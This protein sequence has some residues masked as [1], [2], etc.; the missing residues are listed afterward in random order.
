LP[1]ANGITMLKS[2]KKRNALAVACA[3]AIV[4]TPALLLLAQSPEGPGGGIFGGFGFGFGGPGGPGGPGG[5]ERKLVA[6][7]DHDKDGWLDRAER[8]EARAEAKSNGS[9]GGPGGGRGPGGPGGMRGPGGP[10]GARPI[11]KPGVKVAVEDVK[12]Y[13]SESLYDP[14]VIRTI[15]LQFDS[16]DWEAEM[17]DFKPTDVELPATMIVDGKT[18]ENVGVGFRGAS[19]FFMVGAG[20]KRSLSISMDLVDPDQRLIGY[21]SLNLLN[22][23]G[24]GTLMRSV[25][26]SH[27]ANQF[28]PTP[29][30]NLVRVVINGEDWG[31]YQNAQQFDKIFVKDSFKSKG[32]S[33]WKVPGSPRG[34]GGLAYIGDRTEDYRRIYSIKS[35]DKESAWQ[36][37]ILLCKV[38][39]E[40]PAESL[41]QELSGILDID[42]VLRFLAVDVALI[43]NDGYWVRASDYNIFM[44]EKGI[45]R[46]VPHDMNESFSGA[47]MGPGGG[48]MF[49]GGGRGFGGG[50]PG[51]ERRGSGSSSAVELDPLVALDDPS[52]PLRSKLLKVP[53]LRAKYLRYVY[54][55]AD[56]GLDWQTLGPVVNGHRE[57][58]HDLVEIDSRKLSSNESYEAGT[59]STGTSLGR[60]LSLKQFADQRRKFLMNHP[61]VLKAIKDR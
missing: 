25:L 52:K 39:K 24:D 35:E 5:Q 32:G 49:G 37:L 51:E 55:V 40:T 54:E 58:G 42:N 8:A 4:G 13:E 56:K 31:L 41:E 3:I 10:G 15:F 12:K 26:Y 43:N 18:F 16:E 9:F 61:E 21:K 57:R 47:S 27:V 7:F 60:E 48:G 11:P 23:N 2:R 33:R 20:S 30:V 53:S 6:K 1:F 22:S 34:G 46:L 59:S 14:N 38:L 29:M 50:R 19:S 28:L 45:F 44:D 36:R 17:A